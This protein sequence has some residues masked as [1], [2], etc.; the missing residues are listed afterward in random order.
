[1]SMTETTVACERPGCA[2]PPH[3]LGP[4]RNF[5]AEPLCMWTETHAGVTEVCIDELGHRGAH[6]LALGIGQMTP[7]ERTAKYAERQSE[8]IA[9]LDRIRPTITGAIVAEL[10]ACAWARVE[11]VGVPTTPEA[12][13]AA[14][15]A[16]LIARRG[17]W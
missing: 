10:I 6:T 13:Q 7:T 14:M 9:H 12:L 8:I 2:L 5:A 3:R 4:H 1:M 11:N 17:A 15:L 16:E